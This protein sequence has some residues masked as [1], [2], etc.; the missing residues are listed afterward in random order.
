MK[1][2]SSTR[3]NVIYCIGVVLTVCIGNTLNYVHLIAYESYFNKVDLIKHFIGDSNVRPGL[4]TSDSLLMENDQVLSAPE[5]HTLRLLFL[6]LIL[7]LR[8]F[9]SPRPPSRFSM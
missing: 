6:A 3:V 7:P 9:L 8:I 5:L 4:G 2:L 1:E